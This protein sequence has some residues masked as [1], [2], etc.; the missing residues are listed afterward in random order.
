[1]LGLI[2]FWTCTSTPMGVQVGRA[3]ER[4]D[5]KQMWGRKVGLGLGDREEKKSAACSVPLSKGYIK[6]CSVLRGKRARE[7]LPDNHPSGIG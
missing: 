5:R 6:G 4:K 7:A 2:L 3:G 1:M